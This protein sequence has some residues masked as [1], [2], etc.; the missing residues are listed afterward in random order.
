MEGYLAAG[1][2]AACH[3]H[4]HPIGSRHIFLL[5]VYYHPITGRTLPFSFMSYCTK[6]EVSFLY[7][8]HRDISEF[9]Q[10]PFNITRFAGVCV[11]STSNKGVIKHQTKLATYPEICLPKRVS[12]FACLHTSTST[13]STKNPRGEC[14][15]QKNGNTPMKEK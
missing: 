1:Q 4:F 14:A 15:E 8:T 12:C 13:I 7:H 9:L 11:E 5:Y 6:H 10:S 2:L 3:L